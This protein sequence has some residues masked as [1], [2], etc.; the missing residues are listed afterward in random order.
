MEAEGRGEAGTAHAKREVKGAA[1]Q[2]AGKLEQGIGKLTGDEE[3]RA[4][5]AGK[6][7]KGDT[8]RAG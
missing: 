4:R 1:D 3:E 6:E 7:F 5:G 8:Q 2:A